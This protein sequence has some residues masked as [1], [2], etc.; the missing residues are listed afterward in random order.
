MTE[1][2]YNHQDWKVVRFNNHTKTREIVQKIK[3]PNTPG[4]SLEKDLHTSANEE[5]PEMKSLPKL[6]I[7]DRKKMIQ[8]R[9]S[10]GLKQIDLAKQLN[11]SLKD[12]QDMETGKVINR[13][14]L[15]K[16]NRRLGTSLKI[17]K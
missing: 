4:Y 2:S 13:N 8:E 5:A 7:D 9:T 16:V 17:M 15:Q 1:E 11:L 12:I 14:A 10:K 3:R 6:S